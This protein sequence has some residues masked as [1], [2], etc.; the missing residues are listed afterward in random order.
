MKRLVP[1][2][3]VSIAFVLGCAAATAAKSNAVPSA[4]AAGEGQ[5]S[6]P[7]CEPDAACQSALDQLDAKLAALVT[8][9]EALAGALTELVE[10]VQGLE[11]DL[12]RS[13]LLREK[14]RLERQLEGRKG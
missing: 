6:C 9:K 14:A 2:L 11:T 10:K 7:P 3:G 4:H 5:A 1:G 8:E 12:E 13:E